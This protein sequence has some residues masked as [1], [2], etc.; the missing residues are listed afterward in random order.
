[1]KAEPPGAMQ[2]VVII[3]LAMMSGAFSGLNLG[4]LGLDVKNLEML[5]KPPLEGWDSKDVT[6]E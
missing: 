4:L 2:F 1:V 6:D 3:V 5:C